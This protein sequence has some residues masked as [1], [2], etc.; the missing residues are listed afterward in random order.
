MK[1]NNSNQKIEFSKGLNEE[2]IKNISI[3]KDEPE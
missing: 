1:Q 2:T 3:I